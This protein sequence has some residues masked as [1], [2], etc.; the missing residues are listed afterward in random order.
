MPL[1]KLTIAPGFNREVTRYSAQAQWWDGDHVRF[2]MGY[3]EKIGGY[4]P[5]ANATFQGA[6][7]SLYT[8]VT[9]GGSKLLGIG[10]HLKY[11]VLQG[12]SLYDIT[13]IRATATLSQPFTATAGSAVITVVDV[14]HGCSTGDFVT[15]SGA[16]GLGGNITADALNREF[17]VTV[18]SADVFTITVSVPANSTDAAGSPGGG[19]AVSAAY[20]IAI[21]EEIQ[22]PLEGWSAGAWGLGSWGFGETSFAALRLWSQSSFGEDLIYSPR[23]GAM[24]YW[25][26]SGVSPYTTR[27][28]P[29]SSLP[30]ATDVP[31]AVN[32]V[33][34]SDVSRFVL[35]FGAAPYGSSTLDPMLVRWSDQESAVDWTPSPLNQA[36][37]LRLSVG[38]EIVARLQSRQ[39]V[40]VWTDAAIYS[41]QYQGPPLGWGA[42]LLADN[43]S[44]A[45]PNAVAAVNGRAYWMGNGKFY[46]YDGAVTTLECTLR[47]SIFEDLNS[48][49]M[50]QVFAGTVGEFNEVWW[51]Y[52][53]TGS[54]VPDKYVVHN[55][56]ENTWYSGAMTRYAWND[57]GLF[58]MPL[59]TGAA[60]VLQQETGED[61]VSSGTPAPIHAYA[62]TAVFD[63]VDG[64]HYGF[65]WRVLPDVTFRESTTAN[66]QITMTFYPLK[67]AGTGLGGSV[68]GVLD[69]SVVRSVSVP[70]E[71]FTGQAN[72]RMRGRHAVLRVESNQLGCQ[73]QM[74]TPRLEVRPD[75]LRG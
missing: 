73:W 25:D 9:L 42:Q 6:A 36:G 12:G 26:A 32:A 23:G 74:G 22:T 8:W 30:G 29:L 10:T 2:R 40:L 53:S 3:L 46:K 47:R 50:L 44:I 59:A 11:Y 13:P 1:K 41:M 69:T 66:P 16:A 62:E 51:F 48:D 75:G 24:Y 55:Y 52:P 15:F 56:A 31:A 38:S 58:D 70:V 60:M 33:L 19:A 14:A 63:M 39:E 17:Q 34:V 68:G 67:N 27:G 64:D 28:V 20:Q 71:Q 37:E 35:A 7:R 5:F 45:S 21:G 61:D 18:L 72:I 65:S 57:S 4:M 54:T 43:V 49:Q